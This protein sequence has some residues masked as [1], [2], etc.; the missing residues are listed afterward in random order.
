MNRIS[1]TADTIKERATGA[2]K[3]D[4]LIQADALLYYISILNPSGQMYSRGVWF[5]ETTCYHFYH[6]P[7]MKKAVSKRFFEKIKPLFGVSDKDD[8]IAKVDD[9]VK[10]NRD[11]IQRFNYE[12]PQIKDGLNLDEICTIA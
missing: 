9:V 11:N 10:N 7:L 3:F 5:P 1:L 2:I 4:Q 12:I 6:L 8:F